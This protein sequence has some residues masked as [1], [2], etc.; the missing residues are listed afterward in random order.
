MK[1]LSF[2]WGTG[3]G[4]DG[5]CVRHTRNYDGPA[6]KPFNSLESRPIHSPPSTRLDYVPV[7]NC[8]S[9]ESDLL[10]SFDFAAWLS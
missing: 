10:E 4:A 8:F 2:A 7:W 1:G 3:L 6:I 5:G 9:L